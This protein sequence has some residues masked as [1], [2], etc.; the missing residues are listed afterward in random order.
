MEIACLSSEGA[1]QPGET[2]LFLLEIE[3]HPAR[4]ARRNLDPLERP[5]LTYRPEADDEPL[6][7]RCKS[8]SWLVTKPERRPG[9]LA[10]MSRDPR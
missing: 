4:L 9:A 3:R 2:Q 8:W 5:R 6:R 1:V 7:A 10:W